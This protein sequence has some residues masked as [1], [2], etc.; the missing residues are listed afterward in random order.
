MVNRFCV[1]SPNSGD[2]EFPVPGEPGKAYWVS[3]FDDPR[4]QY[5]FLTPI[6]ARF[7]LSRH[8]DRFYTFLHKVHDEVR[9]VIRGEDSVFAVATEV[10]ATRPRLQ[11]VDDEH[12]LKLGRLEYELVRDEAQL[13]REQLTWQNSFLKEIVAGIPRKASPQKESVQRDLRRHFCSC[14][15]CKW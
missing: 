5:E 2:L 15:A 12:R 11:F 10:E 3:A 7:L 13:H 6:Y 14:T 8:D 4:T 9:K 1:P